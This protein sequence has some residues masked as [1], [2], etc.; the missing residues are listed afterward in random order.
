MGLFSHLDLH[1]SLKRFQYC[2]M[3]MDIVVAAK[4]N[5]PAASRRVS[6]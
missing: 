1:H 4:M 5:D 2:P 3:Q 6:Q